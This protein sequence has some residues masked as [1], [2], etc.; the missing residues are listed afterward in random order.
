V[1]SYFGYLA[2]VAV[3]LVRGRARPRP[4]APAAAT[5]GA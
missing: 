4:A 3:L 5:Q 2:T 1:L